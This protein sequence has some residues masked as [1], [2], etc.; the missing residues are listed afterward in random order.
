MIVYSDTVSGLQLT[1]FSNSQWRHCKR[2]R[3]KW[4]LCIQRIVLST[5]GAAVLVHV[6][7]VRPPSLTLCRNSGNRDGPNLSRWRLLNFCYG[8]K[9]RLIQYSPIPLSPFHSFHPL[10]LPALQLLDRVCSCSFSPRHFFN[11]QQKAII[12]QPLIKL[13]NISHYCNF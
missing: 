6:Q 12:K 5:F 10:L 3:P 1:L 2:Q 13:L 4:G 11:I 9:D 7:L 8:K